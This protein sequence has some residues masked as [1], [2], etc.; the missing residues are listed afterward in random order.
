MNKAER[1]RRLIIERTAPLFNVRG[2]AGTSVSDMTH[3]TGL[4]KGSVYGNFA[5]KEAVALA[6]FDHNW[7]KVQDA[8]R[9]RMDH[10]VSGR[11]KLLAMIGIFEDPRSHGFPEG[12]CPL[13]NTAIESDD[14]HPPL[15]QRA[16]H[17][18]QGWKRQIVKVIESGVAAGEFRAGVNAEQAAVTLIALIEGAIMI[19]RLTGNARHR[20]CVLPSLKAIIRDLEPT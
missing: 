13:L 4:T 7:K 19:S 6:A 2:F 10:C 17:A 3:A 5:D 14:T 12:G 9:A 11:D 1:T 20:R 15:R 8:L 16:M 18:F